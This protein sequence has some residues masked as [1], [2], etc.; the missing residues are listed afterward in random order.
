MS[1]LCI[2]SLKILRKIYG[3]T[4]KTNSIKLA[5]ELNP[6]IASKTHGFSLAAHVKRQ[7]K[8][9]YI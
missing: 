5:C 8:K 2:L 9:M 7:G 4:F 1:N 6:E 3:K